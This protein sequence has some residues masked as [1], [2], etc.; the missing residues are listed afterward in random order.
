MIGIPG[1]QP[2]WTLEEQLSRIADAGFTG[3]LG[4]V[5]PPAERPRWRSLLDRHG[6]AFG[7]M[8]FPARPEDLDPVLEA[9][10]DF[11]AAYINAQVMDGFV[12]GQA[13][14]DLLGG[15]VERAAR[16]GMPFFAETHRGRVTQDLLR[17]VDYVHRL[18][19]LLLTIDLSHYVVGGEIAGPSPQVDKAFA[20]LLARTGTVHARVSN[21]EQVQVDVGDGTRGPVTHFRRWWT[22]G[23]RQW[24]QAARPGDILPFVAE[25]GPPGYAITTPEGREV[26]DRWAQALV[27]RRVALE[28]WAEAGGA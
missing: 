4:S 20:A 17:T 1:G 10:R 5:P 9:A 18:P 27:L 8:A 21:G 26:S 28:C 24:R 2:D 14:V 11:G 3:V 25:L 23:M 6:L 15:L 7:A 19:D 12:V 16:A 13:A 22:E